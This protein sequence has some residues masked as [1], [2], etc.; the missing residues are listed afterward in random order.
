[1]ALQMYLEGL[2]FRAVGRLLRI[3]F[4]TVYQWVKKW[5]EEVELP[6]KEDPDSHRVKVMGEDKKS[7]CQYILFRSLEKLQ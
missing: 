5:G 6:V 3:S 7:A 4:G 2:G 1:M